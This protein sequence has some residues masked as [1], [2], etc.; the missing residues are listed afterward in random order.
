[1]NAPDCYA[2]QYRGEDG[3]HSCCRHPSVKMDSNSFGALVDVLSGKTDAAAIALNIRGDPHGIRRGW[4]IWPANF[5]PV[6]LRNC[7][8]FLAEDAA[9]KTE[10]PK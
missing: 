3:E 9:E 8:G 6:W 10:A 7:D 1:M 4:F 5:D 2:C